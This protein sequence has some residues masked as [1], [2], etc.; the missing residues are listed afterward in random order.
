MNLYIFRA[1]ALGIAVALS[2]C[3]SMNSLDADVS[4]YS[5]WPTARKP[6]SYVFERLPS[7]Q[8]QE[9]KQDAL[10][11]AARRAFG[12]SGFTVAPDAAS[13][14]VSVQLSSRTVRYERGYYSDPF[15]RW[16]FGFGY[17]F[18]RGG[19]GWGLGASFPIGGYPSIYE[20]EVAVLIR[21]RKSGQVLYES[22]ATSDDNVGSPATLEAMFDAAMKDFPQP[23]VNPRRITIALPQTP[24]PAPAP[25]AK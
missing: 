20:R 15:W 8:A 1:T 9:Q 10:E 11:A 14:D 18:G 7:Q 16:N 4:S 21:D 17:P 24:A 13:A 22:R 5:Q 6:N 2:G 25:P 3:A 23:A 12:A 19:G